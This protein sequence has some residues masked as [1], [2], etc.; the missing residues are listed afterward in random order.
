M[1]KTMYEFRSIIEFFRF[2]DGLINEQWKIEKQLLKERAEFYSN[3]ALFKV[4]KK[5]FE[6]KK[7]SI[8]PLKDEEII[9]WFDTIL[10]LRRVFNNISN[11]GYDLSNMKLLMEY[12]LIYGNHMRVDYIFIF[13]RFILVFELG[14]FNQDERRSEERYTKK[15]QESI[16]YRQIIKNSI[17]QSICVVN[18]VMIYKPEYDRK[19]S[20]QMELNIT[21]NYQEI[22]TVSKFIITKIKEQNGLSAYQQILSIEKYR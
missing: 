9:T 10:L 14:M 16:A 7:I 18:Y 19:N 12:P 6:Q 20:S 15:L 11:L 22:D 4:M 5:D 17:D 21:Y 8:F 2:S 13:D 3:H 1:I